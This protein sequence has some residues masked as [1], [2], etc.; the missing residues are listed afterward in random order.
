M[1]VPLYLK[2]WA[3]LEVCLPELKMFRFL[4]HL[5]LPYENPCL[6]PSSFLKSF[7]WL[8][9]LQSP[10]WLSSLI[11]LKHE[12]PLIRINIG[13]SLFQFT[14]I[15]NDI[16]PAVCRESTLLML[17]FASLYITALF[18]VIYLVT[19]VYLTPVDNVLVF[20]MELS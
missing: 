14:T 16:F 8:H 3:R 17:V 12:L 13:Y 5:H 4:S 11:F 20:T 2:T 1:K 15:L 19:S 7:N 6:H 10:S 18:S 9:W